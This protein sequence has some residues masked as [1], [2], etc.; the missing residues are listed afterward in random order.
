[1]FGRLL[2]AMTLD[3]A[4]RWHYRRLERHEALMRRH[5]AAI[6]HLARRA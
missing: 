6:Q 5:G 1:M 3:L 2:R 4:A